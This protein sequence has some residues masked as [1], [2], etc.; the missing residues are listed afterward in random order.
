MILTDSDFI[1]ANRTC[2]IAITADMSFRTALAAVFKREYKKHRIPLE[3]K[4][5]SWRRSSLASGGFACTRKVFVLLGDEGDG[6][7]AFGPGK[8]DLVLYETE[9][10][11]C[12]KRGR[13]TLASSIR[14]EPR[15]TASTGAICTDTRNLF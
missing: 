13:R 1:L 2:A 9:R 8:L 4:T 7:A 10:L 12:G 3:A 11:S 15:T 5:R 14:P 6:E